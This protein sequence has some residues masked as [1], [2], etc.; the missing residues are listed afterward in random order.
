MK[1]YYTLFL[2]I[3]FLTATFLIIAF[4]KPEPVYSLID[5]KNAT[6]TEWVNSKQAIE[7]LLRAIRSNP[8]DMKS[9]LKLVYAYIQEGRASGNHAYYDQAAISLC[10]EILKKEK[11]NYEA[12]C[13]KATVLLSQ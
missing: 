10:D 3:L 9:K 13:A 7:N 4:R 2:I 6:S 1:K 12:M 8:A 5:R 11:K